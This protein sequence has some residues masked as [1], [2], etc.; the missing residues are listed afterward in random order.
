MSAYTRGVTTPKAEI[1]SLAPF[2]GDWELEARFPW[3][4]TGAAGGR[5]T[6]EWL[7]DGAFLVERSEADHPDA[8]DGFCLI[9]PDGDGFLQHYFDSRGVVRLYRM[10]FRDGTWT[11]VRD[12]GDFSPLDFEQQFIGV[13]EDGGSTIRGRWEI[14]EPGE[15]WKLDFELDYRRIVGG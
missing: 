4:E 14:K 8:P 5:A 3:L 15:D 10:T 6:F 11:L 9:A 13:F 7:F 2:I 12:A 1:A